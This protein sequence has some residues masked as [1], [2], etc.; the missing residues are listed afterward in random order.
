MRAFIKIVRSDRLANVCPLHNLIKKMALK[1]NVNDEQFDIDNIPKGGSYVCQEA[2]N[3]VPIEGDAQL[4]ILL[5]LC[6]IPLQHP[7]IE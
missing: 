5:H 6:R 1:Q 3:H 7:G 4:G 2:P